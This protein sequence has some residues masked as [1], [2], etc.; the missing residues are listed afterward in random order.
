MLKS[1]TLDAGKEAGATESSAQAPVP[2]GPLDAGFRS[3][4]A[5]VRKTAA[6][7][8]YRAQ[9][10]TGA[11]V[12]SGQA[13]EAAGRANKVDPLVNHLST[14]LQENGISADDASILKDPQFKPHWAALSHDLGIKPPSA[15]T[16]DAVIEE[17]KKREVATK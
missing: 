15:K 6:N 10:E 8:N 13:Y 5:N 16:I 9:Q 12:P 4:P 1:G 14:K 17:L 2:Q 7:A 3:L 11:G